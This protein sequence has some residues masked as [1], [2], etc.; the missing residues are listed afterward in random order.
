MLPP[1]ELL[2]KTPLEHQVLKVHNQNEPDNRDVIFFLK[3]LSG[4]RFPG[5]F[6][7]YLCHVK[8]EDN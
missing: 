3:I 1:R 2:V 8:T 5:N 7:Y 4:T 6:N